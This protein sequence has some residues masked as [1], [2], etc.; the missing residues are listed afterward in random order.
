MAAAHAAPG[1]ML[2]RLWQRLA[3]WPAVAGCSAASLA[4]RSPYTGTILP[5]IRELRPG[6]AR[7]E[8]RDRRRVRNHLN[9]IHAIALANLGEVTSG[10]AMLTACR[11]AHAVLPVKISTEYFKKARGLLVAETHCELP[12]VQART[13]SLSYRPT[14][15]IATAMS[16]HAPRPAGGWAGMSPA[17]SGLLETAFTRQ[18]GI[19]VPIICGAMYPCTNPELVAVVSEAGGIGIIQPISLTYVYRHDFRAGVRRIRGLTSKP[20][21]MNVLI[22]KS[23]KAYQEKMTRWLDIALEEGVRFIITS[24]GKPD[25][26]V[27]TRARG[28]W[29]GVT[30]T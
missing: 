29:P 11:P 5:R 23:S 21:G 30:T 9:S 12:Q 15:A 16:W 14:S 24:L 10:L 25:W 6:Y 20:I 28:R 27:K 1:A 13:W 7:V 2:L 3:P 4:A 19:E 18:V 26:V 22:E 17:G 8:L